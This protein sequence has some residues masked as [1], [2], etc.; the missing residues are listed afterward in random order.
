ML[1][2]PFSNRERN[3]RLVPIM[4]KRLKFLHEETAKILAEKDS[5]FTRPF[6]AFS[7][8]KGVAEDLSAVEQG[9]VKIADGK[10]RKRSYAER[11]GKLAYFD[12]RHERVTRPCDNCPFFF[13]NSYIFDKH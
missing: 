10:R 9:P 4:I 6:S 2:N 1:V 12:S 11:R 5:G 8:N 7:K 3:S 13:L